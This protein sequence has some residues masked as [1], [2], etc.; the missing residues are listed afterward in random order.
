MIGRSTAKG[1]KSAAPPLCEFS[2]GDGAVH[3]PPLGGRG[4]IETSAARLVSRLARA[5]RPTA[6]QDSPH[7]FPRRF[8]KRI[9]ASTGFSHSLDPKRTF[10]R[11]ISSLKVL[12][13]RDTQQEYGPVRRRGLIAI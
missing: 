6:P 9:I 10:R 7:H 12:R 11:L 2:G 8:S 1:K 3:G 13:C 5:V 4:P